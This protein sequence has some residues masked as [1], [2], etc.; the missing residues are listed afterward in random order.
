MN[1]NIQ[2]CLF[3]LNYVIVFTCVRN[4]CMYACMPC[5][6]TCMYGCMYVYY[7]V[8]YSRGDSTI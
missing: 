5:M 2:R 1:T 8:L 4:I 7:L 3:E 6:Y